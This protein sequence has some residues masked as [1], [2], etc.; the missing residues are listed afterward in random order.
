MITALEIKL[1]FQKPTLTKD[2]NHSEDDP[3]GDKYIQV[4]TEHEEVERQK[5]CLHAWNS[6]QSDLQ[7]LHQLFVD[8]NKIV[9]VR[10]FLKNLLNLFMIS[11]MKKKFLNN[12]ALVILVN[13]FEIGSG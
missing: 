7:Q 4:Q 13:F 11:S 12:F 8:F 10:F 6:L 9:H 3:L 2:E 1:P 5:A